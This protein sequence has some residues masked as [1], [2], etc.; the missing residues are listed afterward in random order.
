MKA[1]TSFVPGYLNEKGRLNL[2]AEELTYPNL[3]LS[4]LMAIFHLA[5]EMEG[6]K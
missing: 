6:E 3:S 1:F 5:C 4:T 2:S